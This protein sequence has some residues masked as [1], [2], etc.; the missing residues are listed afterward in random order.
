MSIWKENLGRCPASLV[1]R[2]PSNHDIAIPNEGGHDLLR[3]FS[4]GLLEFGT[5]DIFEIHRLFLAI[6]MDRETI[7][8]MDRHDS[9]CKVRP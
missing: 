8:L 4:I 5:I 2:E 6:V 7:A 9:R 3:L 1:S